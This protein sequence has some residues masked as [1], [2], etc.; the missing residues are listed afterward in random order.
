MSI[1][2]I[3]QLAV[4]EN[5]PLA[6]YTTFNIGGRARFFVEVTSVKE[7]CSAIE[8]AKRLQIKWFVLGGGSNILVADQGFDGLVIKNAIRTMEFD[9]QQT[10]VR[11]GAGVLMTALI[12]K[13]IQQGFAGLEYAIGVPATVG[14]AIWANLGAH[15][16]EISDFFIEA[17]VLNEEGVVQ[18]FSKVD[19]QFSYRE[20]VFKHTKS[21]ILDGLFQLQ[22]KEKATIQKQMMELLTKRNASQDITASCAGCTFRNPKNQ[23]D[24]SAAQLIDEL[25]LKGFQIGGAKVSEKHANFIVNTGTATAEDVIMLISYI[26]QQVRDK[27]GIQLME[28][29]EYI[30]F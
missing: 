8:E 12:Q 11:V 13:C 3:P 24:I 16:S 19:C 4:Q 1:F 26:K 21:I 15:G 18:T 14:G 20:S 23:T 28:E 22:K 25:G 17:T 2:T 7:L 30:G 5:V 6:P 29:V 27:K 10:R 9:D